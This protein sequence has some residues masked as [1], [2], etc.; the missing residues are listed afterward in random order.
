MTTDRPTPRNIHS[1]GALVAANS[2]N[3]VA[4]FTGYDLLAFGIRSGQVTI[5]NVGTFAGRFKLFEADA[6]SSFAAGTLTM[7]IDDIGGEDPLPIYRGEIGGL[8]VEGIDLGAFEPGESRTYRFIAV[9]AP[10]SPDDDRDSTAGAA[11]EWDF[12]PESDRD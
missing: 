6:S 4:I 11:Y 8:P 5:V 7:T 12:V 3:G 10:A 1:F 9:I 2:E